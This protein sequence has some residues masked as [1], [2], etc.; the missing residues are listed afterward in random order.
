MD[1][2]RRI[3]QRLDPSLKGL[4]WTLLKD[5]GALANAQRADLDA[6]VAQVASRR[7]ARAWLY[8]EHLREILNR[9]QINVVLRMLHQWCTNVNRSWVEPMKAV[10]AWARTRKTNGFLEALCEV[11]PVH[12]TPSGKERAQPPS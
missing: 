5:R 12:R 4:R 10:A 11:V 7:T 3:E 2:T 6:L 9:K 1:E 8:R